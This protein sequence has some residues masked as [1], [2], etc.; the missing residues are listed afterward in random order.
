MPKDKEKAKGEL[1]KKLRK[2]TMAQ[3][4]STKPYTG[5]DDKIFKK[6]CRGYQKLFYPDE[7]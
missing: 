3:F 4:H 5:K 2:F 1:L 7:T 6:L